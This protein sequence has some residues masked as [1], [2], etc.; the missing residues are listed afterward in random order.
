[1][2]AHIL[3]CTVSYPVFFAVRFYSAGGVRRSHAVALHVRPARAA[4]VTAAATAALLLL[5]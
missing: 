1:M 3:C 4:A 5:V 2:L